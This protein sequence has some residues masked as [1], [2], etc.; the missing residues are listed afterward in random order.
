MARVSSYSTLA[1]AVNAYLGR[2]LATANL[3]YFCAEAEQEM[4]AKLRVRFMLTAITP[5]VSS[6]GVITLPTGFLG[7]K[8]FQVR[9]GTSEWDL[10]LKSAEQLTSISPLYGQAGVPQAVITVG[11][12][13][14]IW[15]Y[16]DAVYTFR[17]LHYLKIPELASGAATNWVTANYPM[18]YLY[19]CL[20]AARGFIKDDDPTWSARFDRWEKR[21]FRAI[22]QI[23]AADAID[24]DARTHA[25]LD[26]DTSLFSGGGDNNIRADA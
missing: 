21:F 24:L 2:D 17:G 10:A 3:D 25:E 14:Q 5:T 23:N 16:T 1:T 12:T 4:N 26:A 7:W 18:A 6:A 8:R 20:M 19:G 22:D 9:D 11:A 15:P 13:S